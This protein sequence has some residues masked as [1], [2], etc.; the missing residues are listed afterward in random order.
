MAFSDRRLSF[1][2]V[3]HSSNAPSELSL[4]Q[5]KGSVQI[6]PHIFENDEFEK[7]AFKVQL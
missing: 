5:L 7:N 1:G 2:A 3:L 4:S 6:V